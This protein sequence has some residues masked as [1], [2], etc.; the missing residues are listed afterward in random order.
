MSA[1]LGGSGFFAALPNAMPTAPNGQP[2]GALGQ[3]P[4]FGAVTPGVVAPGQDPRVIAQRF[5]ALLAALETGAP[6]TGAPETGAPEAGAAEM[7]APAA[8]PT[9][10]AR[11]SNAQPLAS[12]PTP[13]VPTQAMPTQAPR[14]ER[15]A[16]A[17]LREWIID[18]SGNGGNATA[19]TDATGAVPAPTADELEAILE[20]M[21]E[22]VD[23]ATPANVATRA[24]ESAVD[25]A[26][27][28]R[29]IVGDGETVRQRLNDKA[30]ASGADEI[31]VMASGPSL[32]SRIRSLELIG[33]V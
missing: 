9:S 13:I 21:A 10:A 22:A 20:A 19:D 29:S 30:R 1:P 5:S 12:L 7:D 18:V 14:A 6:E 11:A 24:S 32:E 16:L 4:A 8:M 17:A 23:G 27:L 31:F 3:A 26:G 25:V 28:A 2:T 33:S 15:E